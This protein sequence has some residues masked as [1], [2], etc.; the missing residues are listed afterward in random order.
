MKRKAQKNNEQ[1]RNGINLVYLH[2]TNI[3][4]KKIAIKDTI[5]LFHCP[6]E[7]DQR[8]Y[9]YIQVYKSTKKFMSSSFFL[10]SK[11]WIWIFSGFI[12]G[13][14]SYQFVTNSYIGLPSSTDKTSQDIATISKWLKQIDYINNQL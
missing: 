14:L 6:K 13:F 8:I 3:Q 7:V 11:I 10:I 2:Y 4:M 1:I 5:S 12:I 9:S